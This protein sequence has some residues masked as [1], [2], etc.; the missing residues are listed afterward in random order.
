MLWAL[1]LAMFC[2]LLLFLSPWPAAIK[3][4]Q[5]DRR[6]VPLTVSLTRPQVKAHRQIVSSEPT[7]QQ[8]PN[9]KRAF[10]SERDNSVAKETVHRGEQLEQRNSAQQTSS[11]AAIAQQP[12]QSPAKKM[13]AEKTAGEKQ[14]TLP[15]IPH[16][17]K[18]L[19]LP[20]EQA[21]KMANSPAQPVPSSNRGAGS[22][23]AKPYG[24]SDY[25]PNV[26]QGEITLLN[27]KAYK[28]SIFVRRVATRVFSDLKV[29]T[30]RPA[31]PQSLL[32]STPVLIQAELSA[33]GKLITVKLLNSSG[34]AR[35]DELL[36]QSVNQGAWDNN[37]PATALSPSGRYI[38]L[39]QASI[40]FAPG[41]GGRLQPI[42]LLLETGLE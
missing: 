24:S 30:S 12:H 5:S 9:K 29:R 34:S 21:L 19:F 14:S 10:L 1:L 39:F 28:F 15:P 6:S 41:A 20:T 35:F 36:E 18:S 22:S 23:S 7:Q 16:Q 38:F 11:T 32:H 3:Q 42:Q 8:T 26:T 27:T 31:N 13:N 33:A 4:L 17:A 25:L 2:H 37:P 40:T